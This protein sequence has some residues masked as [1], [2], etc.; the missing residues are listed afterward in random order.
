MFTATLPLSADAQLEYCHCSA[1]RSP[2]HL[3][4]SIPHPGSPHCSHI[5][6]SIYKVD[7]VILD[8]F[9]FPSEIYV[10]LFVECGRGFPPR[11]PWFKSRSGRH[12]TVPR[13]TFLTWCNSYVPEGILFRK[14]PSLIASGCVLAAGR[15]LKVA[16]ATVT[17][18]CELTR[19]SAE[20]VEDAV[21][22]IEDMIAANSKGSDPPPAAAAAKQPAAADD[23]Q[24]ETPPDVTD[25]FF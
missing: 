24:P 4:A 11:S 17:S 18:V 10:L 9:R 13:F 7:C 12:I 16:G 15:G 20:D 25:V 19:C 6:C 21:R 8:W 22:H 5:Y 23:Y 2:K 14:R 1:A 3:A